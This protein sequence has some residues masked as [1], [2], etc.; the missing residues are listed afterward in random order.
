MKKIKEILQTTWGFIL[1]HKIIAI[2]VLVAAVIVVS[3]VVRSTGKRNQTLADLQ[4][5]VVERGTLTATVGASGSAH[6]N[7]SA[8]LTWQTSGRVENI[9][10][11]VGDRVVAGQVLANL[12]PTSLAQN[13]ILAQADQVSAQRN[14]DT[15]M[16]STTPSA[17][18]HLNQ[19]NAQKAFNTAQT[20]FNN[21]S[22]KTSHLTLEKAN[23]DYVLAQQ[24]YDQAKASYDNLSGLAENDPVR[25]AAYN[26]YYSAKVARDR[27]LG[28]LNYYQAGPSK[29]SLEEAQV[30]LDLA[31]AQLEDAQREWDRLKDGPDAG[32]ITAAQAR[33]N[34]ALA[35][36][37]M[38]QIK[39]PFAGTITGAD[40]MPGDLVTPG[41]TAFR[42]DDLT[43]LLVDVQIP[44]VDINTIKVGQAVLVTFDAALG[45]EYH[46]RVVEV[47][48]VGTSL[49]GAVNFNVTV[50]LSDADAE[51]RPGM[52]A[53]VTITVQQ[54]ENA[55]LVQ[56]RAV[57]L[58]NGQRV[59]FV[60]RSGTPVEVNITLGATS[61][62]VSEVIAGDLKVGDTIVLN[63]PV[64]LYQA[65]SRPGFMGP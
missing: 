17:Q 30:K 50:V 36:V 6:A 42:V 2:L 33:L 7:Q 55:L 9:M 28:T 21:L 45:K 59:V 62:L 37:E 13:I 14:L 40:P 15:L 25:A 24:K 47:A 11:Q 49:Q 38:A 51:V 35:A 32:D 23:S 46:G 39:A 8:I 16:N 19:V 1:R 61:D 12:S 54:R 43:R 58:I 18:A 20:T 64:A 26:A 5:A 52:T 22:G 44:E 56:N 41:L 57:R 3:I 48:R 65:D 27:A 10:V 60:L 63:P 4:T 53:A 31:R 34:A 29:L